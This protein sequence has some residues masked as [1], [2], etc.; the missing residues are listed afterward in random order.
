MQ[1]SPFELRSLLKDASELG[2][3]T[4]LTKAGLIKPW[5]SKSDAYR[6]YGTCTVNRWLSEGLIK[7]RTSTPNAVKKHINLKEIEEVNKAYNTPIYQN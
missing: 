7:L 6:R 3:Q 5:I 2:A 4:A 1:L